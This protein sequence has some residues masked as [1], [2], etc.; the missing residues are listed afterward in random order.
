MYIKISEKDGKRIIG[1]CDMELIGNILKE[2]EVEM[3]LDAHKGFF[4]GRTVRKSEVVKELKVFD[5]VVAVGEKAVG[6]IKELELAD[7]EAIQYI[8]GVP[9]MYLY[10]F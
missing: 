3:D 5:S 7:E 10:R 6:I 1:I 8:N 2:G 9:H 4:M